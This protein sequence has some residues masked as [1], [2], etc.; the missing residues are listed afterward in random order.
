MYI[1]Q[2]SADDILAARD[3]AAA[4]IKANPA[5]PMAQMM[6]TLADY[7]YSKYVRADNTPAYAK[8]LG[9]LDARELYPDFQP[10]TF[11]DFVSE[12]LGGK[13]EMPY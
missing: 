7:E 3:K 9:Y 6:R 2:V 4:D 11:R 12:L 5:N 10:I 13:M 8:Y 1:Y